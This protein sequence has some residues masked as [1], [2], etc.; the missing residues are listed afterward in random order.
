[1]ENYIEHHGILGQ[2]WGGSRYQNAVGSYTA[3][4]K[5]R[6]G[7]VSG[8]NKNKSGPEFRIETRKTHQSE[9][10]KRARKENISNLSDKELQQYNNRLQLEQNFERLRE[11]NYSRAQNYIAKTLSTAAISAA[12]AYAIS[13]I[14]ENGADWI[15]SLFES[16]YIEL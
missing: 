9:T 14:T 3:A 10:L 2:K 15:K 12:T 4:G 5:A 8:K 6:R 13:K 11:D 1:M 16:R 7:L